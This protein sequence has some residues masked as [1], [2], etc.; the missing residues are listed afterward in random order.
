VPDQTITIDVTSL[1]RM[2][3]DLVEYP[4]LTST[5]RWVQKGI[6]ILKQKAPGIVAYLGKQTV[7]AR[8]PEFHVKLRTHKKY[9][10]KRVKRA[11]KLWI[12]KEKA[13]RLV[14]SVLEAL[15]I[16]LT[17]FLALLPGPNIFFYVPALLLY[18]HYRSYKGLKLTDVDKL[19]LEIH[20][21]PK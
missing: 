1:L 15:V 14:L 21:H 10:P 9:K 16:P 2:K 18:F 17:P 11:F 20:I 4:E 8:L 7:L 6:D 13:K 12:K 19:S 5:V 3:M